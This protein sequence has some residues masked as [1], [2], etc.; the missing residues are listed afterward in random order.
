[1][2][3]Q[4]RLLLVSCQGLNPGRC[5][6]TDPVQPHITLNETGTCA[7]MLT[8]VPGGPIPEPKGQGKWSGLG[9]RGWMGGQGRK[10]LWRRM[11]AGGW[12]A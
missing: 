10:P 6:P 1:M 5:C 12:A 11:G 8:C 4:G 9:Q 7:R 2:G 3:L